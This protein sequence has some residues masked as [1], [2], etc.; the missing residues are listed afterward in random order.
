IMITSKSQESDKFWG[1]K[2]GAN[3]YIKK[4]YEPA[5]LLSAIK[6]YLG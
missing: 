5:E 2:Q 3:E 1:M 6:K 4:P